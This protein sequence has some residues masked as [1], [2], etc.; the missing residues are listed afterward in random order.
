MIGIFVMKELTKKHEEIFCPRTYKT[1]L[2]SFSSFREDIHGEYSSKK[3]ATQSRLQ[4][5]PTRT[6]LSFVFKS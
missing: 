2:L 6:K 4:E 1:K 3:F 5:Q